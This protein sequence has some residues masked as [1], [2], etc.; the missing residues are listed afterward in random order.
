MPMLIGMLS[1]KVTV[2]GSI[3]R[4]GVAATDSNLKTTATTSTLII[5]NNNSNN[6]S[7]IVSAI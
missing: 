4:R 1:E 5:I 6:K 3:W 2:S 7:A